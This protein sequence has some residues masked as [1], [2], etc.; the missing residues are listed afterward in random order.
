VWATIIRSK[1]NVPPPNLFPAAARLTKE[2]DM[3]ARIL[4]GI[5]VALALLAAPQ[6]MAAEEFPLPAGFTGDYRDVDGV[7]LHYVKGGQGPLVLL[8]HGFGQTW[9]EWHQLMPLLARSFTV[10]APDLPGLG[11]SEP[12]RTSY[13]GQDVSVYLYKLAKSFS[14]DAPFNLVA[15]DIGIWNTYP[16]AVEHQADIRRLAYMEAPIPD[17]RLYDFPAFTPEGESLVWHFSFFTAGNHLAETLVTGR[18]RAFFE[19]FI[20]VHATNK[21]VFTP[22]LLDMYA[23][24]YA[25]P[26]S[27]NAAFEYYRA[28]NETARRNGDLKGG[29][30]RMPVMVVGGGGHG[31][32]AEFEI[33]QMKDYAEAVEAHTINEAGHW[34]PEETPDA[35]NRLV[36]DFLTR[37]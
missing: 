26:Q 14:P 31:G 12:P 25:K 1:P 37:P 10:V 5:A 17:K 23:R 6:A 19:H 16:M 7:K 27:L 3:T 36:V 8:V 22:A 29:K 9:Y 32:M 2:A 34:L 33:G 24:S 35:L 28:L 15:H 30:L 18:E 13:T 4:R 21:A 11:L 20:T